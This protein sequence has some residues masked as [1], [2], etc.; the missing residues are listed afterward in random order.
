MRGAGRSVKDD[1][2]ALRK[3][4]AALEEVGRQLD[5][6]DRMPDHDPWRAIAQQGTIVRSL[7]ELLSDRFRRAHPALVARLSD[8]ASLHLAWGRLRDEVKQAE[9]G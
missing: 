1:R 5:A 8:P 3:I 6:A 2:D 4:C 9:L 7:T